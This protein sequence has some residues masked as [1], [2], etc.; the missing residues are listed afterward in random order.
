MEPGLYV[1]FFTEGE[2]LDGE[3]PPVGP[4][5]HIVVRDRSL[6][7][8]RNDGGWSDVFGAG[9][10]WTEAEKEFRRA[11]GKE[12][13]GQ[14]RPDLRI[15]GPEGVY[16]RFVSFGEAAEHDPIPELGPYAVVVVGRGGV[17][18]DGDA[19]ATRTGSTTNLWEL[20]GVGGSAFVGVI[21]PDIAFRTR[22]TTYH[23]EIKPFRASAKPAAAPS[24]PAAPPVAT[25]VV[26][27]PRPQRPAEDPGLT[28]RNRI[29]WEP[30]PARSGYTVAAPEEREWGGAAWRLRYLI[31]GAL[32]VLIA[33]FSVPSIRSVLSGG[34]PTSETV[35]IGTAVTSPAW[36]Y[37][38]GSVRRVARIGASQARG[39]YMVVQ[40]AAT[41]RGASGA[42]VSPSNF[43]L[44]AASGEQYAAQPT[45]SGVYSSALNADSSYIWPADFP[46]GR[47]VV[48]PLI[49]EV[50][51][52]TS[53]AQLVILDVPTTRIRLE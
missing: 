5:E 41:N 34:G 9:A 53:G 18:A 24:R 49:F 22:S 14:K 17:E 28:L 44:V 52:T 27:P 16:L 26:E 29:G 11:T 47:A 19:I 40:I 4:L 30:S 23:P 43:T 10:R 2:P 39:T 48:V 21:R 3:L 46:V 37:N 1:T 38:V 51:A 42:Q 33:V 15:A 25:R 35:G 12:P 32:V 13:G 36:A 45:T 6:L 8:Q 50:N 7:A 20:T 31:I